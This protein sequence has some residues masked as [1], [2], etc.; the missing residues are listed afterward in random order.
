MDN[1]VYGLVE[2][3]VEKNKPGYLAL[4]Q[5]LVRI[6]SANPPGDT[7]AIHQYVSDLLTERG[8]K[9]Q[10]YLPRENNPSLIAEF[11]TGAS[12][13]LVI[14]GHYDTFPVGD[15]T[16]WEDDPF[17]GSVID[18]KLF[19]RGASDMKAGVAAAIATFLFLFEE[20]I[21]LLGS[22][23]LNL[24]SDEESGSEWGAWWL[25]ENVP[26]LIGDVC[27]IGEPSGITTPLIG[28]KAPLWIKLTT[29][30]S[31]RH[32]AYS[33]GKDAVWE[34]SRAISVIQTLNDLHYPS[35]E[36]VAG[37]VKAL[38]EEA[39]AEGTG[40]DWWLERPSVNFG[41]IEG[42]D[43]VNVVP[44]S[45][46]LELDI[47]VPFGAT[48][49]ELLA[50]LKQKLDQAGI[51]ADFEVI[52]GKR[53]APNFTPWDDPFILI[54]RQS[55]HTVTGKEPKP[56]MMPYYTDERVFRKHG[57]KTVSCGPM[58][59]HMGGPNEHIILDEYYQMIKI[60]CLTVLDYCQADFS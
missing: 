48:S 53:D 36:S 6:P 22:V 37:I 44:S 59:Y 27:L 29:H 14:N 30:S 3:L 28:Q 33:D 23:I 9:F 7:T 2:S 4:L 50:Q 34:M 49:E 38:K 32:G 17:S 5:D 54:V 45:C 11:G 19:G 13:K 43:K 25:A 55:I 52:M 39:Q 42:G 8:I 56:L 46:T 26:S 41:H 31:P 58:E 24:V 16:A 35:P 1:Q 60:F 40:N 47:R 57:V 12:P 10:T 18:G 21:T 51:N 20:Q 15:P